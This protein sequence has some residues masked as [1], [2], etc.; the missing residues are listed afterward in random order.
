VTLD[1]E[2]TAGKGLAVNI[3]PDFVNA[4]RGALGP[5]AILG[6]Y[7]Q[8]DQL[9][10]SHKALGQA[11]DALTWASVMVYDAGPY[12]KDRFLALSRPW[13]T[14]V[15]AD[16]YLGGVAVNYPNTDGGLSVTQYGEVLDVATQEGWMGLGVWQHAIFTEPWRT[17]QRSKWPNL[18]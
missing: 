15:G 8:P 17:M 13:A 18:M 9:T 11:K 1:F 7:T 5:S 16:K 14:M 6:M 10:T 3:I 4:L 2:H 12:S